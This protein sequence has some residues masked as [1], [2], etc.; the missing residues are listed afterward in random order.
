MKRRYF[1]DYFE[2]F[3][4]LLIMYLQPVTTSTT[5]S[6]V[7]KFETVEFKLKVSASPSKKDF[8]ENIQQQASF[9]VNLLV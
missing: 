5:S 9:I 1:N 8:S 3:G 7:E 2:K 6:N 4:S